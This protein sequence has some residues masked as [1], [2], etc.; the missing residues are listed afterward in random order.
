MELGIPQC[1]ARLQAFA[2]LIA[3]GAHVVLTLL[4]FNILSNSNA[5]TI[6]KYLMYVT[7]V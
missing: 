7:F 2:I 1:F 6:T 3:G 4:I 5:D